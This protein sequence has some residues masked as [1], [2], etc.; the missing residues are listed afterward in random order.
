MEAEFAAKS[1]NFADLI[2]APRP[3][4]G[5]SGEAEPPNTS[6]LVI[7]SSGDLNKK[8]KSLSIILYILNKQTIVHVLFF[9]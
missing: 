3:T 2:S 7:V 5:K 8:T 9:Y 6:T 4:L 1:A